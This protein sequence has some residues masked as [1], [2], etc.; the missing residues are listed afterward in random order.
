[1]KF[2]EQH[3]IILDAFYNRRYGVSPTATRSAVESHAR[4]HLL[5]GA[6]Y[7]RALDSAIAAGLLVSMSDASLAIR[8]AGRNMLPK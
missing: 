1:V 6:D 3:Q 2:N 5:K 8:G 7:T 4:R